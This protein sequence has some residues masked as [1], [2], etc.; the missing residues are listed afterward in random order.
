MSLYF[1]KP[2]L[3]RDS[4]K[5]RK[6]YRDGVKQSLQ[7][8]YFCALAQANGISNK[9]L[10]RH[11]FEKALRHVRENNLPWGFGTA[12]PKNLAELKDKTYR[13]KTKDKT[14]V[15]MPILDDKGNWRKVGPAFEEEDLQHVVLDFDE[16]HS[17]V[18]FDSSVPDRVQL[19]KDALPALQDVELVAFYSSSVINETPDKAPSLNLRIAVFFDKP[20]DRETVRAWM[21][22]LQ[23]PEIEGREP[24]RFLDIGLVEMT[25]WDVIANP[26]VDGRT[27]APEKKLLEIYSQ[28]GKRISIDRSALKI[29]GAEIYLE[30]AKNLSDISEPIKKRIEHFERKALAGS[31]EGIRGVELFNEILREVRYRGKENARELAYALSGSPEVA[32][33]KDIHGMLEDASFYVYKELTG[34][35]LGGYAH[36]KKNFSL[37]D[38]AEIDINAIDFK[39]RIVCVKSGCGTNK[40]KGLTKRII[41]RLIRKKGYKTALYISLLKATIKPASSDISSKD[42]RFVYYE[43][44]G[45]DRISKE[46]LMRSQDYLA[47]T[48]KS[49]DC[50]IENGRLK[51]FDLVII[52][53][54]E[55]VLMDCVSKFGEHSH[56][57]A[58]CNAAKTVVLL[59]ADATDDV[60]GWFAKEVS[61]ASTDHKEILALINGK[62]WMGHPTKPHTVYELQEQKDYIGI[63]EKGLA[64]GKRI[65][66]HV[67]F[68]DS[69]EKKR[70]SA[71]IR[72]FSFLYPEKQIF[73]FDSE[74]I[75]NEP[76]LRNNSE[77]WIDEKIAGDGLD[78]L[79]HS[80][81]SKIGW[82]FLSSKEDN[83]FDFSVGAYPN[84]TVSA[85]D[86][87][88]HLRRM[89]LTRVHYVW[90]D[91]KTTKS[92]GNKD[93]SN[94][95][96]SLLEKAYR[97]NLLR[98]EWGLDSMKAQGIPIDHSTEMKET[99]RRR[100]LIEKSNIRKAFE[101]ICKD[102]GAI[103][104]PRYTTDR[105]NEGITHLLIEYGKS[106]HIKEARKAW[107][108]RQR[109]SQVLD[110]F[111]KWKWGTDPIYELEESWGK[112][113]IRPNEEDFSTFLDLYTRELRASENGADLT[114]LF[115]LSIAGEAER[116][117]LQ[118]EDQA[119]GA[120][121][122]GKILDRIDELVG[123]STDG[124]I[125][126]L[127]EWRESPKA[128]RE[129]HVLVNNEDFKPIKEL[130][131]KNKSRIELSAFGRIASDLRAN[132]TLIRKLC[133][134]MDCELEDLSITPRERTEK[135]K[136]Q[137][138][139]EIVNHYKNKGL[140]D[141]SIRITA[142]VK[143]AEALLDGKLR[144]GIALEPIEINFCRYRGHFLLIRKPYIESG[145]TMNCFAKA[146]NHRI[147]SDSKNL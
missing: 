36:V 5:A 55:K 9:E 134:V 41:K 128:A 145:L 108:D 117:M 147:F 43:A 24:S 123:Q 29:R 56:I 85:A 39:N 37:L 28:A 118:A 50:L 13:Y 97:E 82:D 142:A 103:F 120:L 86:I 67:G 61:D 42:I 40:T 23:W 127:M 20:Y 2:G 98:D 81:W 94:R 1:W 89:R 143:E 76:E 114:T 73:G 74:S 119:Q 46:E 109:R 51:P 34:R 99:V 16:K 139:K 47:T 19:I 6:H 54:S 140:I 92:F 101:L 72:H 95:E 115:R 105:E 59:D 30:N 90:I 110:N 60:T 125:K 11:T 116:G 18:S 78:L 113:P 8:P 12:R 22:S 65:F 75:K 7:P 10:D 130:C 104:H 52:D 25:R 31:L 133:E 17:G 121:L 111:F 146:R 102:R 137:A 141:K 91:W 135:G 68:K 132:T 62:D 57:Y 144:E 45:S 15:E 131:Q 122:V 138:N 87:A 26:T 77:R 69:D 70:I 93:S 44:N 88:Q 38:C 100:S 58:L 49:L 136:P 66:L 14:Y 107:D 129:F 35:E 112:T 80:P 126:K 27:P 84:K 124:S 83:V 96:R 79:I 32:G 48:N 71:L 106:E 21:K 4:D 3:A 53:E 64:Q 63:I 33:D